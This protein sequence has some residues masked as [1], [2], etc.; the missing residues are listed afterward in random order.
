V[1]AL[2][3]FA[4]TQEN[5]ASDFPYDIVQDWMKPLEEGTL[6]HP[7]SVFAQSPDR[8][9]VAVAGVTPHASA[10]D[11]LGA[12]SFKVPGAKIAHQISVLNRNGDVI[13]RWTQWDKRV[14]SIHELT[15]NPYDPEKH[16]WVADRGSQQVLKFTNDGKRL[17]MA[18]GTEGVVGKDAN[19]FAQPTDIAFLPD[20]TFFVSDGDTMLTSMQG[21]AVKMVN[22]RVVKFDKDGKYLM[23]WDTGTPGQALHGIGVDANRRVYVAERG[24]K[25]QRMLVFDENGKRLNSWEVE[26]VERPWLTNDGFIWSGHKGGLAKYD[27]NGKLLTTITTPGDV[28]NMRLLGR[29]QKATDWQ[30]PHDFFAD[31]QGNLYVQGSGRHTTIKMVPKPN[32]DRSRIVGP[33]VGDCR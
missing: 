2:S 10:P 21:N 3:T 27:L 9:Y 22:T 17:V 7:T 20:G 33:R 26:D 23:A 29:F 25:G 28:A 6:I 24:A 4:T 1:L 18:I 11:G 12:F 8:I 14:G 5:G 31:C 19:H 30:S 32:A 13:E 15:M 16:L